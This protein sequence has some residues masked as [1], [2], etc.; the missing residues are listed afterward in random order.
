MNAVAQQLGFWKPED[1]V[2]APHFLIQPTWPFATAKAELRLRLTRLVAGFETA[3]KRVDR[4]ILRSQHRYE[5][6]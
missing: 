5:S 3:I 1:E 6:A 2:G 4:S